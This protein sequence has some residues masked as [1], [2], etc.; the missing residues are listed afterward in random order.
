MKVLL[1]GSGGREHALAWKFSQSPKLSKLYV[2]PGNPGIA[3]LPKA[4]NIQIPAD[5]LT[6]L[7]KFAKDHAIDLTFVG[8]EKPLSMGI[9]DLFRSKGLTIFGPSKEASQLEASKTFAKQIMMEAEVPTANYKKFQDLKSTL[10][11][12]KT[13][14]YP[15]VLKADGLASGKGVAVCYRQTDAEKFSQQVFIDKIFGDSGES[16][17][18]EDFLEG[19]ECSILAICDGNTYQLLSSAQDH[20]RLLD[21]DQGPN[22]GGMGAYS[23]SPIFD[24]ILEQT[25]HEHVFQ[26]IL[27]TMNRKGI[28]YTG[29]LYAGL[30]ITQDGPKVLEFNARFGDP[31]TQVI[32]PRLE[33]DLLEVI[34]D[35]SRGNLDQHELRW[36]D[37]ACLTVVLASKGYPEKIETGKE[38]S[39]LNHSTSSSVVFHAGTSFKDNQIVSSGGR[40]L[41]VTALGPSIENA[42]I[43]AY[44]RVSQIQFDGMQFRKDIGKT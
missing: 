2:A 36:K 8:P 27:N 13:C 33:N 20:K 11:Y 29:I 37:D 23:P 30:M 16:L 21:N 25:V 7:V 15:I 34:F 40:V 14:R 43:I 31:E 19:R 44:D 39:G 5:D 10:D 22:T 41:S 24:E 6:A 9:V 1:V 17:I 12:L 32:L 18:A 38:I 35:A 42:K 28:K 26:P 3:C 4:E